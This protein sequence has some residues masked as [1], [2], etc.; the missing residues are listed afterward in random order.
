MSLLFH[1]NIRHT[2]TANTSA[3]PRLGV[4]FVFAQPWM[5]QFPGDHLSSDFLASQ[6][7]RIA[8]R[9]ELRHVYGLIDPYATAGAY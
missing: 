3:H 4:W 8:S 5:R 9:P 2:A 1:A 7:A 6:L